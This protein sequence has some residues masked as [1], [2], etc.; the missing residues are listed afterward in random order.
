MSEC[1]QAILRDTLHTAY[2]KN[3]DIFVWECVHTVILCATC[4]EGLRSQCTHHTD[5]CVYKISNVLKA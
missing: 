5:N 3:S 1:K 4:S 2:P